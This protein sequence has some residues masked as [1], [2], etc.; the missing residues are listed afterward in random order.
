MAILCW[1]WLRKTNDQYCSCA[2]LSLKRVIVSS[3][4]KSLLVQTPNYNQQNPSLGSLVKRDW[5]VDEKIG[6]TAAATTSSAAEQ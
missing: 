2:L 5:H 1:W 4:H 3:A 6:L